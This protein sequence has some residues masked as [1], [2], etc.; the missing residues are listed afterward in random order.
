MVL[1]SNELVI[2]TYPSSRYTRSPFSYSNAY[3]IADARILF[4]SVPYDKMNPY[5]LSTE[6]YNKLGTTC[7]HG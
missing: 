7:S 3:E 1:S 4:H 2:G 6:E 5:T